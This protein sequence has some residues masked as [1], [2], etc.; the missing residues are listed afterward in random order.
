MR[1]RIMVV[2][3]DVAQRARLARLLSGSGYRVEIAESPGH[4]CRIGFNGIDVAIVAPNGLGPMGKG[5]VQDLRA[6]VGRVLLVAAP[7]YKGEWH[8]QLRN[9]SGEDGLLTRV[10]EVLAPSTAPEP[11]ERPVLQFAGYHLDLAGHSLLD[12]TGKEVPLTHGEFGLLRVFVQRAGRVLSR[13]QLLQLL[14]GR[15]AEA[16]DRSSSDRQG[17]LTVPHLGTSC[18]SHHCRL[19]A[20]FLSVRLDF[21]HAYI[22]M[23]RAFPTARGE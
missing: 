9:V 17:R 2:S 3:R 13:D 20:A 5:L 16:Y 22:K 6:A 19:V 23:D 15:D 8:G 7:G 1:S 12:T 14:S 4:A 18:G 11:Q 21:W 10:A